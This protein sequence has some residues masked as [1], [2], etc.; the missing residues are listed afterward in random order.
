MYLKFGDQ[1]YR[2]GTDLTPTDFY[3]RLARDRE[4]AS[5]SVPSP[6][7]YLEAFRRTG[8]REIVCVTVASSMSSSHQQASFAAERFDGTVTV[9]DSR[10]A[11]MAE[12]FVAAEAARTAAAGASADQVAERAREVARRA[13]LV[14]TI[15]TFEFLRRSGRVTKLQA[16]AATM[17]DIKPVF[18]FKD[19]DAVPVAR[20]RTRRRALAQIE[21]DTI[22]QAGTSPLHLAV[23]HAAA[24]EEARGLLGRIAEGARGHGVLR[25][26]SGR[27]GCR[28]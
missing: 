14:A 5:T 13:R 2:D 20:T 4:P 16:Y 27:V 24:E 23:I 7:E 21:R 11:S 17:L 26:G 19:G 22:R 6:G 9:V 28:T 25:G 10:T 15:G 1:V 8:Q 18:E 12:G 3:E